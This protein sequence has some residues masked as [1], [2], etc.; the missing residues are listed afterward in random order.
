MSY[1]LHASYERVGLIAL[2]NRTI[3]G[4]LEQAIEGVIKEECSGNFKDEV[5]QL[6][7]RFGSIKG[8]VEAIVLSQPQTKLS[9]TI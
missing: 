5:E 6:I 3:E 4:A 2:A 7:K 9:P 8:A 1:I